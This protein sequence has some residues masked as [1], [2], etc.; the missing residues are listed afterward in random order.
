MHKS[1]DKYYY[2]LPHKMLG[3]DILVVN[4][5]SKS[6]IESPK[7]FGGYAGD[8]IGGGVIRFEKGPNNKV[9]LKNISYNVNPDSKK[10]M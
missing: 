9:F 5:V 8:E 2:E 7:A 4:R 10:P 6:S 1:E 3:W